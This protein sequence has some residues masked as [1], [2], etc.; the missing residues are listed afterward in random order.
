MCESKFMCC[1]KQRVY[2][3][4]ANFFP[5]RILPLFMNDKILFHYKRENRRKKHT[6]PTEIL[7]Y[8]G[9]SS[10][11]EYAPIQ[12]LLL[13]LSELSDFCFIYYFS[14]YSFFLPLPLAW[15]H[16][17]KPM[18][19]SVVPLWYENWNKKRLHVFI[20]YAT[21]SNLTS[22]SLFSFRGFVSRFVNGSFGATD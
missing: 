7:S 16:F 22:H 10:V 15:N 13:L 8:V 5:V 17:T 1:S 18:W 21:H 14:S 11:L 6:N 9:L 3:L 20:W 2:N 4:G 12:H 19:P